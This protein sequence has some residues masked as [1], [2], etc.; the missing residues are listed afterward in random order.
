MN[1]FLGQYYEYDSETHAP[2]KLNSGPYV[3]LPAGPATPLPAPSSTIVVQGPY[4]QEVYQVFSEYVSHVVRLYTS[5]YGSGDVETFVEVEPTIGVIPKN[6]ELIVRYSTDLYNLDVNPYTQQKVLVHY[7]DEN[8]FQNVPRYTDF[9]IED[10]L[11]GNYF[12]MV[13]WAELRNTTGFGSEMKFGVVSERTHGT[14]SY[15]TGELEIMLHRRVMSDDKQGLDGYPLDDTDVV[16]PL[17]RLVLGF[18]G[19][20]FGLNKKR[21]AYFVNFPLVLYYGSLTQTPPERWASSYT[22]QYSP[23]RASLPE[24]VHTMSF[25]TLGGSNKVIIRLQHLC[26]SDEESP[27]PVQIDLSNLFSSWTLVNLT[28]TTLTANQVLTSNVNPKVVLN[29]MEVKTFVVVFKVK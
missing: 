20:G 5:A 16:S 8:G 4:V 3:F 23:L 25:K 10:K 7:S 2:N 9:S 6:K 28:E 1:Y 24:F 29:N 12:P 11:G 14:G 26:A 27:G 21:Q 15:S 17:T 22:T 13:M 18:K 19:S